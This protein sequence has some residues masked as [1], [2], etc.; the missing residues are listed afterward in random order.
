MFEQSPQS[1]IFLS[2]KS[3]K[4]FKSAK[5]NQLRILRQYIVLICL[6]HHPTILIHPNSSSFIHTFHVFSPPLGSRVGPEE[7][8]QRRQG[9]AVVSRNY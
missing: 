9:T 5:E 2:A 4:R 1:S 8:R 3:K 6:I 7:S